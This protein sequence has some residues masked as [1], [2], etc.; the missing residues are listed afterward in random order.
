M[1]AGYSEQLREW[2][3]EATAVTLVAR[4]E[5]CSTASVNA[6][7]EAAEGRAKTLT[8]VETENGDSVCGGYL[9]V[10]WVEGQRTYDPGRR[11][12][13]F[14]LRN[15]LGVLPTKFAQKRDEEAA[16]M[17]CDDG[18]WFGQ[19]EGFCVWNRATCLNNGWTYDYVKQGS[20]LFYGSGCWSFRAWRWE[21]WQVV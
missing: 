19:A 21:L 3:P 16:Y 7:I 9:D 15:H 5:G 6:F 18:V 11:G 20:A 17:R 12:F 8:F 4:H 14:T 10:P 1:A 2:L 13:I